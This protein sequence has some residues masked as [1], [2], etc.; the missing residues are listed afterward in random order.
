MGDSLFSENDNNSEITSNALSNISMNSLKK[1]IGSVHFNELKK[2]HVANQRNI[3]T[4]KFDHDKESNIKHATSFIVRNNNHSN[5]ISNAMSA[6]TSSTKSE[7][8]DGNESDREHIGSPYTMSTKYGQQNKEEQ[9]ERKDAE[10]SDNDIPPPFDVMNT[11]PISRKNR[12]KI[13]RMQNI[14]RSTAIKLVC[15]SDDDETCDKKEDKLKRLREEI[16]YF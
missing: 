4:V 14:A 16:M 7:K 10:L 5:N 6:A 12:R 8:Y 13:I 11:T 1:Q 2:K 9:E 3:N 15:S